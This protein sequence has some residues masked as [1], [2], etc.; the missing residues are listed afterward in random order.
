M[1]K[2]NEVMSFLHVQFLPRFCS[3]LPLSYKYSPEYIIFKRPASTLETNFQTHTNSGKYYS[4][5][6]RI[7]LYIF[8]QEMG[9][10][11]VL[12]EY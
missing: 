2:A 3:S 6:L 12:N 11:K 10:Q 1:A 8:R 4:F 5:L 9:K 7:I